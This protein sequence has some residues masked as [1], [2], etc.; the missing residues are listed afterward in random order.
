MTEQPYGAPEPRGPKREPGL[1]APRTADAWVVDWAPL[2]PDAPSDVERLLQHFKA[3]E[4]AE[5]D[6]LAAYRRLAGT[7]IDPVVALVL[8][9]VIEDEERHHGLMRRIIATLSD[10]LYWTRSPE[11]LP[12]GGPRAAESAETRA[13][14]ARYAQQEQEGVHHLHALA[15][16][17]DLDGDGLCAVL[18]ESMATDSE[19]HERLLRYVLKRLGDTSPGAC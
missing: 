10:K 1:P 13:A 4:S 5:S 8:R 14:V 9:L 11:A 7:T 3:H 19:K 12:G 2:P 6:T 15:R 17:G 18:V 16:D